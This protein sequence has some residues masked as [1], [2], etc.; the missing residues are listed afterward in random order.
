QLRNDLPGLVAGCARYPTCR[1]PQE[2]LWP[3]DLD[4]NGEVE[5]RDLLYWGAM[6]GHTGPPRDGRITWRGH[7]WEPWPDSTGSG[8]NMAHGDATGNGTI[9][10]D[11]LT[12]VRQH[13]LS[14]TSHPAHY[15]PYPE[16]DDLVLSAVIDTTRFQRLFVI[17]N[18]DL[19][20]IG[21]SFTLEYDTSL[22]APP[23]IMILSNGI[24]SVTSIDEHA[25]KPLLGDLY[26]HCLVRTNR[27]PHL[28]PK[29]SAILMWFKPRIKHDQTAPE[30]TMFR[31][32]DLFALDQ[33]GNDLQLGST[34]LE[35]VLDPLTSAYEDP[36]HTSSLIYPNPTSGL[37]FVDTPVPGPARLF[38][39]NGHLVRSWSAGELAGP[40]SLAD[41]PPG[42]YIL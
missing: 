29:G 11:D 17:A 22:F 31:L 20:L 37:L 40:L 25:M 38:D 10:M 16:G 24:D 35:V 23:S 34:P 27:K 13:F 12:L 18:R 33:Y 6:Q 9:D 26:H 21:L 39:F 19:E 15:D 8:I 42:L 36:S 5:P 30:S 41:L 2:C 1:E 7:A 4:H 14:R 28:Y 32:R 3:G